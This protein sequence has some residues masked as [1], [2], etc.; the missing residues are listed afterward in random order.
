MVSVRVSNSRYSSA[1][2]IF[3]LFTH[4]ASRIHAEFLVR[5]NGVAPEASVSASMPQP[6]AAIAASFT[7]R[8]IFFN[9]RNGFRIR[10]QAGE[11]TEWRD[12]HYFGSTVELLP[13]SRRAT[14]LAH[15]G[16]VPAVLATNSLSKKRGRAAPFAGDKHGLSLSR[17]RR[18][19]L[20][21]SLKQ[22]EIAPIWTAFGGPTA[23]CP[24]PRAARSL[25]YHD[26]SHNFCWIRR[27]E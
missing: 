22:D 19:R 11:L 21:R 26:K 18:R 24:S 4:L 1:Y 16:Q 20:G 5:G 7:L 2:V 9:G 15:L 8:W 23:R 6:S 27:Y 25:F 14:V 10:R 17:G 13:R 12:Q 3:R